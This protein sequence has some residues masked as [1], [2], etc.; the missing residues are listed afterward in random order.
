M[1]IERW[2]STLP[3]R[4][5]ALFRRRRVQQDLDDEIRD[6]IEQHVKANTAAGMSPRDARAAALR[7]FGNVDEMKDRVRDNLPWRSVSDL[8][9]DV[10][11]AGRALRRTPSFTAAA[12]LSLSL[13][14]GATTVIFS[15][16]D[17]VVI[18]ALPYPDADRLVSVHEVI[19]EMS[20]RNP[21]VPANAGHY[22][23]WRRECKACEGVAAF[24]RTTVTRSDGS[25]PQRLGV[26]RA[27]PDLLP[28][29]GAPVRL[30]RLFV[31]DDD[32]VGHENVAV[33][34]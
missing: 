12:V 34:K 11:L 8:A 9:G 31:P 3:L 18:R 26:V 29:L 17:H 13:G 10:R 7:A 4:I 25:D 5:R 6:H 33:Y 23:E 27:S 14:V 30:G 2:V 22:L 19:E 16:A 20:A 1:S 21:Q 28:M 15:V 24:R 32:Q